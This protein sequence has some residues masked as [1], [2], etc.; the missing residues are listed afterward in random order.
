MSASISADD[1]YVLIC[2]VPWEAYERILEA[3]GE[4]HLR[5][6][7]DRGTLE[8]RRILYGVPPQAYQKLMEALPEQYLRHTYDGWT[9]EM[10][11][12]RI[13][14]EWV[15]ELIGRMLEAM[16][17]ALGIPIQSIGSTTLSAA[18][19]DR[20]LQPD[21]SYY[22]GKRGPFL[23]RQTYQP[24]E[25]P[26]P[27]LVIEVDVT[28]T[29][30]PRLPVFARVGIPEIWRYAEGEV[31]FYALTKAGKYQ[32]VERSVAFPFITPGDFTRFLNRRQDTDEN[33]VVRA[34][35]KWARKAH[36]QTKS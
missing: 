27:D 10:M 18:R 6:T 29:V 35:V 16:A 23:G 33:S 7:Y 25:S 31:C 13:D 34:F 32:P 1:E 3:V 4:F 26:P 2:G 19:G 28:N 17:L 14:H 8:M 20:G 36:R 22:I 5:H 9:L 30:I 24:G 12:P 21:Q 15:A 11:T